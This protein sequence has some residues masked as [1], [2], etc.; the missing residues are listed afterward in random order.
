M[1]AQPPLSA[2]ERAEIFRESYRETLLFLKH[3]DDKINR[4]LTALAFLTTAGV[5]LYIFSRKPASPDFPQFANAYV[6]ADDYFFG[7]F[8]IG[9]FASV[10]LALAA[11]DPTSF[12]PRFV[13]IVTEPKSILFYRAIDGMKPAEWDAVLDDPHLQRRLAE[14]FHRDARRLSHRATHKVRR[15]SSANAV[16]QLTVAALTLLGVMRLNHVRTEDRWWLATALLIV[17]IALPVMDFIY[18]RVYNFPG[19]G[20][21][22]ADAWTS[23]RAAVF[24]GPFFIVALLGLLHAHRDWQPVTFALFGTAAI[25]RL[26]QVKQVGSLEVGEH[27]VWFSLGAA[28]TFALAGAFWLFCFS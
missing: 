8:L 7:V 13:G 21:E 22:Y 1:S 12:T 2:K 16:V 10:V 6:R 17:Y 11:L 14:D 27:H 19:V 18:L 25:R 4:V 24:Y 15:F 9:L 3:Q 23:V 28:I 26:A 5:T 20:R